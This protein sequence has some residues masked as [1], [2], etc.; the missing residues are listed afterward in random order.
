MPVP[1]S[2][3]D[4]SET[5]S[6][7][8]PQ[9]NEPVGTNANE[10]FQA[11]YSFI[12]QL[13]NGWVKADG[14]V[15]MTGLLT[16]SGDPTSAL[17]PA[18]KQYVDNGFLPLSGGTLTGAL[19]GISVSMSGAISSATGMQSKNGFLIAGQTA[20]G[21]S[22]MRYSASAS[23]A[24]WNGTSQSW[25]A[26]YSLWH[27]GNFAPSSYATIAYVTA[28]YA[29]VA[30]LNTKQ[31][32]GNYV[33]SQSGNTFQLGWDGAHVHAY[34]DSVDGGALARYTEVTNRFYASDNRIAAGWF[35]GTS[36]YLVTTVDS[37]QY[38][39]QISP[40]DE[41]L[42]ENIEPAAPVDM[43]VL[44]LIELFSFNYKDGFIMDST[45]RHKVGFIAQ[46]LAKVDPTFVTGDADEVMLQ[47][48]LMPIVARL[49]GAVQQLRAEVRSLKEERGV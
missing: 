12:K 25:G 28:T 30:Q 49:V 7:N 22:A 27:S 39:I 45:Q 5:P 32:A 15:S 21:T 42:K 18:S 37:T 26:E 29:T 13:S 1:T 4:L 20:S 17:N 3:D 2:L 46:Q 31:N 35:V 14:T 44:D 34:I 48:N 38:Q 47:P 36:A 8:S 41:R 33:S 11:A 16:L 23:I 24:A 43:D 19:N 10:Y 40:S 6:S 9:G